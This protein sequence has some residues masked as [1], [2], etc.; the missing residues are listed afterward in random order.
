LCYAAS[1]TAS[2]DAARALTKASLPN[3]NVVAADIF[4]MSFNSF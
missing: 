3:D 1:S 2:N 4:E